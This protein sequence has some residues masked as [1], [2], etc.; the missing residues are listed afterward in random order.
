M[1]FA[2]KMFAVLM[3][4]VMAFSTLS[5][6]AA[7]NNE[8][9]VT[10]DGIPVTFEGQGPVIT[11]NRTL[12][13]VRGVFEALG[14]YPTW[15]PVARTATLTRHDYIVVLTIGSSIFTTNGVTH[16]L[17]VPAQII[18]NRTLLPLRAV[19]ESVGYDDM[20]WHSASRTVII[21]TTPLGN[22][23][24]I[25][26]STLPAGR[27]GQAYNQTLQAT[28]TTPITWAIQSGAL[29]A[30]VTLNTATGALTGTPTVAGNFS[31]TVH[32]QN[33]VGNNSRTLS[34]TVEQRQ[35]SSITLPSR[36][37]TDA[38]RNAWIADYVALGGPTPAE[39]EVIRLINV[40]RAN[41]NL[42][43]VTMDASLMRA[44]RYFA[45][46]ANDLRGQ[47][48]GTHNFGPYATNAAAQ[49]GA[50][51]NVAAAFGATLRTNG[52]NWHSSGDTS[53]EELVRSWMASTAHRNFILS[54]EH[55]FIG[56]GQ[57]PGGIS[58][59]FM[60]DRASGT[61]A[62]Q[63][64]VTFRANGGTGTMQD[65]IFTQG[66]AQ[67][68]RANTFTRTGYVFAGW[69]STPTGTAVYTNAQS[70][71]VNT[72]RTL[73]AVWN[74]AGTVPNIT[75]TTLTNPT[76]RVPYTQTLAVTGTTPITWSISAGSLPAGLTLNAST[77]VISGT[78]T[79]LAGTTSTFTV[80][81]E[82]SA[83]NHTRSFSVT[84]Q[85]V[86]PLTVPNII[87]L[88]HD[89]A[90][91]QLMVAPF[92]FIVV[93]APTR[94]HHATIPYGHIVSRSPA[95]A[96]LLPGTVV[97][98]TLSQGPDTVHSF[99][100]RPLTVNANTPFSSASVVLDVVMASGATRT[101]SG[102]SSGVTFSGVSPGEVLT[103]SRTVTVMY[104]N[105]SSSLEI[106]VLPGVIDPGDNGNG[107]GNG[108]DNGNGSEPDNG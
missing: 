97:T 70:I 23:P 17:D 55:R 38:E 81:A 85:N 14:F 26:T 102:D 9:T 57:F 103:A 44:A 96:Q 86:A 79:A 41:H 108:Y 107:N 4:L 91:N 6:V 7:L 22:A 49:H 75:T 40:E 82:N 53:P 89:A 83:G 76:Y 98:L 37:A 74:R 58:Y 93:F 77:G 46:Q 32:A 18:Q 20:D 12:V 65:Q 99:T 92:N 84:I 15:D 10:I 21:R 100:V 101:V 104:S 106:T 5:V 13:P 25:T 30:G 34:I 67:N 59:M 51:A 64:T 66:V 48:T 60:N 62:Q 31:F 61:A 73:Y 39:I 47:H 11:G 19:L 56:V 33:A 35:L 29:P 50:S 2:R 8:I 42:V 27:I 94:V 71:T 52:G 87:G 78:P 90:Q 95:Y 45:Q 1:R 105:R 28:G 3:V 80:R 36:R 68:L 16:T 24:T 88:H 69:R 43:Q 63:H 54:P 72:N